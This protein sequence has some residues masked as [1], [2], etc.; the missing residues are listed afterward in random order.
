MEAH[1]GSAH[2]IRR[3]ALHDGVHGLAESLGLELLVG[4]LQLR[5]A[6]DAAPV[7]AH[8]ALG[9]RLLLG[10]GDPGGHLGH[11][12]EVALDEAL[13]LLLGDAQVG[14]EGKGPLAVQQAEVHSLGLAAVIRRDLIHG[15]AH[16]L[17]GRAAVDVLARLE[18][19]QQ[20]RVLGQG[21]GHPQLD[22]AVV[23]IQQHPAGLG[24][25]GAADG[26]ALLGADGDVLQVGIAGSQAPGGHGGL[27]QAGVYAA[28]HGV[29]H[30]RQ[31]LHVGAQQLHHLPVAQQLP[32]D[33]GAL[34]LR[35]LLEHVL[36]GAGGLGLPSEL[37]RLVAQLPEQDTAKLGGAV[38]VEGLAR[39]LK[40]SCL[41]S[42]SLAMHAHGELGKD[43][44]VKPHTV[45]FQ[46]RQHL[47]QRQVHLLVEAPQPVIREHDL[48][49]VA[50]LQ[51]Q[52]RVLGS[53]L[54]CGLELG[55]VEALLALPL[56]DDLLEGDGLHV[57]VARGQV[58]Q[59]VAHAALQ[60]EA[61]H[62]AVV[63]QPR[64]RQAVAGQHLQVVLEV[65][66]AL[67]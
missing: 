43:I 59:V 55:L 49:L 35:Q 25:E 30:L 2:Q 7:G 32:G 56:A 39:E 16:D 36:V 29:H 62:H 40:D 57:Q 45:G 15:Q 21:R 38:E 53:V 34:G 4:A 19:G 47:H 18:G 28:R 66:A 22:L 58:I 10:A 31:G 61:E 20:H 67:A 52:V 27:V 3:G 64:H 48:Q 9:D 6:P 44:Q 65:L 8:K 37:H 41:C 46:G 33:L 60:Q 51:R 11:A 54:H 13:R 5:N 17:G 50:E 23:R 14:R 42:F 63:R 12:L 26:P 24:H 1:H